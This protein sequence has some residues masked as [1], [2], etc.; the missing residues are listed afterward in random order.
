MTLKLNLPRHHAALLAAIVAGILAVAVLGGILSYKTLIDWA[1]PEY[2][3]YAPLF[4]ALVDVG[5][6]VFAL[7]TFWKVIKRHPKWGVRIATHTTAGL[8]ILF[9][10]LG[11]T[12]WE[13]VIKHATAPLIFVLA[14]ETLLG[15]LLRRQQEIAPQLDRIRRIRWLL[16]PFSTASI[17]R[18]MVLWELRSYAAAME[19]DRERVKARI[20]LKQSSGTRFWFRVPRDKRTELKLRLLELAKGHSD[21]VPASPPPTVPASRPRPTEPAQPE[22]QPVPRTERPAA[23]VRAAKRPK[24]SDDQIR[25]ALDEMYDA[26]P[27][28]VNRKYKTIDDIRSA[29]GVRKARVSGVNR[30]RREALEA[31]NRVVDNA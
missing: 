19:I 29:L 16:A 17:W 9:N 14:I 3:P 8:S 26:D 28:D 6:V 31:S 15:I 2:G 25:A 1:R 7:A 10:A 4:A 22:P 12:G 27:R 30:Q 24:I 18:R 23:P 11:G 13:S 21:A 20:R 5:T